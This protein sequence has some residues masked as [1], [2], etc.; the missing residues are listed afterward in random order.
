MKANDL[1]TNALFELM[2]N[3]EYDDIT[4]TDICKASG[5][6]RMSFYRNFKSKEDI[7]NQA[8]HEKFTSFITDTG[9]KTEISVLFE[10]YTAN[11][12]LI[13]CIYKAGK[14][15]LIIDQLLTILGYSDDSPLEVQYSVSYFAYTFFSFL[16]VWYKRGMRETAEQ[17]SKIMNRK[18]YTPLSSTN[19][20][21][22]S[23]VT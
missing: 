9:K 16:D 6:T 3:K 10:F 5:Y 12:S 15:Q 11:K 14:Q 20:N 23:T 13:E 21:K 8:F 18:T 4:V 22:S 1:I 2:S 17:I 7:L 19:S